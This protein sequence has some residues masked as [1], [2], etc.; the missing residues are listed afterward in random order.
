MSNKVVVSLESV[1]TSESSVEQRVYYVRGLQRRSRALIKGR[2]F[3]G[4]IGLRGLYDVLS[5]RGGLLGK[6]SHIG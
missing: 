2:L 4:S 1:V 3:E 5:S 6:D